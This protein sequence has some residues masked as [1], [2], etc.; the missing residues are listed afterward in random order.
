[1]LS[2]YVCVKTGLIHPKIIKITHF[3]VFMNVYKKESLSESDKNL[4]Q[5]NSV[6]I[7]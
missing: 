3:I 4:I 5:R 7:T 2:L 1:M 6:L